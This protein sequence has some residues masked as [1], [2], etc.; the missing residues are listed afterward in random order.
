MV[1]MA[2]RRGQPT[3]AATTTT[4]TTA[5]TTRAGSNIRAGE[6]GAEPAGCATSDKPVELEPS[7]AH[8]A[9]RARTGG[10]EDCQPAAVQSAL[11]FGPCGGTPVVL[12][13]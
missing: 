12:W 11:S 3:R 2:S 8:G 1:V 4:T 10:S 9:A 6:A 13:P 7:G 5:T